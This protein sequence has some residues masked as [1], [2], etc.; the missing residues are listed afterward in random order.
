MLSSKDCML[1]QGNFIDVYIVQPLAVSEMTGPSGFVTRTLKLLIIIINVE[2][3]QW[4]R[5]R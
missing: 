1:K 5:D 3:V 2:M 4:K